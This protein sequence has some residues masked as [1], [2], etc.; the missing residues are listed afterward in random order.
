MAYEIAERVKNVADQKN[1]EK[2]LEPSTR[3]GDKFEAAY[4]RRDVLERR[5]ELM[6]AWARFCDGPAESNVVQLPRAEGMS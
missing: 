2:L 5:G 1:H 4:A 6:E 3:I